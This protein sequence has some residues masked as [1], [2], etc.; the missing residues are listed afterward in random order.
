YE[1]LYDITH[2]NPIQT[3]VLHCLYHTENNVLLGSPTCSDEI[4]LLGEDRRIEVIVSR[5]N[6]I[7]SL[8]ECNVRIVGL[9][10]ALAN[11]QYHANWLDIKDMRLYNF[12]LSANITVFVSSRHQTRLTAFDLITLDTYEEI[13]D[14]LRLYLWYSAGAVCVLGDVKYFNKI[15][16]YIISESNLLC[17]HDLLNAAPELLASSLLYK[18][19]IQVAQVVLWAYG[20]DDREFDANVKECLEASSQRPLEHKHDWL[21]V[22]NHALS[23]KMKYLMIQR[24]TKNFAEW[25]NFVDAVAH[26]GPRRI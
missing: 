2:F 20:L 7:T 17:L 21:L 25:Q 9:S 6:F 24:R 12:K 13:L 4:H 19:R 22:L 1:S 8:T 3:Q 5:T 26:V 11:A 23:K 14:Y 16:R 10:T 18:S 15:K